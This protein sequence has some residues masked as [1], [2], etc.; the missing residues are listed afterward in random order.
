[1]GPHAEVVAR[2]ASRTDAR[3][4]TRELELHTVRTGR[5]KA[6]QFDFVTLDFL[7]RSPGITSRRPSEVEGWRVGTHLPPQA[8]DGQIKCQ[9]CNL[10]NQ[11][12]LRPTETLSHLLLPRPQRRREERLRAQ[13]KIVLGPSGIKIII[14]GYWPSTHAPGKS[15]K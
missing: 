8:G 1:M 6:A 2:R 10:R 7:Y 4:Y 13:L 9:S 11:E 5:A 14:S 15:K 3:P 12:M